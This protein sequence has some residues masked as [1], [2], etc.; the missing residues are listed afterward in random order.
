MARARRTPGPSRDPELTLPPEDFEPL[1]PEYHDLAKSSL[2]HRLYAPAVYRATPTRF[3]EV[4]PIERFDHQR[5]SSD[6]R[7][8][9]D[10]GRGILYAA[11]SLLCCVGEY[12]G[13]QGEIALP[14]VRL[15]RLTVVV[16]LR[17][18][19]L[20]GTAATGAGTIPAISGITQRA[21]TQAW[22]RWW[23]DHPQ[24]VGVDGLVYQAAKSGADA[25][26]LTERARGKVV[27][28]RGHHWA[29]NDQRLADDL[30]VAAHRLR[31]VLAP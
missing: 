10:P 16:P 30:E 22:A 28:R 4:G 5:P 25:V 29:L 1:D 24:L 14:G 15:A 31:L 26:A 11:P 21:T 3:R 9:R 6:G 8:R 23:Y 12:F 20:R 13:D 7:P 19:D 17:L 2:L 27:C 18:L